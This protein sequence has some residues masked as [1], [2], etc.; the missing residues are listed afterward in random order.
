MT[1]MQIKIELMTADEQI[2]DIGDQIALRLFD[3]GKNE[4]AAEYEYHEGA[5]I[6]LN[7]GDLIFVTIR[8]AWPITMRF[9]VGTFPGLLENAGVE[10]G[11]WGVA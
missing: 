5:D 6:E 4:L 9:K 10:R 8:G 7:P 3:C 11:I 1:K 2:T